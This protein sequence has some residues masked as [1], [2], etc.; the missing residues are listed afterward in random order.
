[1]A[2]YVGVPCYWWSRRL[3][4][5]RL[6]LPARPNTPSTSFYWSGFL[7]STDPPLLTYKALSRNRKYLG[8]RVLLDPWSLCSCILLLDYIC[9]A[10]SPGFLTW[11]LNNL[12]LH[13]LLWSCWFFCAFA[14]H[15]LIDPT[16]V[17]ALILKSPRPSHPCPGIT[18]CPLKTIWLVKRIWHAA[19]FLAYAIG[20]AEAECHSLRKLG[21]HWPNRFA[22]TWQVLEACVQQLLGRNQSLQFQVA[23]HQNSQM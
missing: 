9:S 21:Q 23:C 8:N 20:L 10:W 16:L 13:L 17:G 18:V 19:Q 6:E 5:A 15:F 4:K 22:F 2:D 14:L 11:L 7:G 12:I 3:V 1:M